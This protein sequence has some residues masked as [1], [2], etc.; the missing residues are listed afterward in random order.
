[1]DNFIQTIKDYMAHV[2]DFN[3]KRIMQ[4]AITLIDSELNI[5]DEEI[6]IL[7]E[8]F[9]SLK[10]DYTLKIIQDPTNL[11]FCITISKQGIPTIKNKHELNILV[12]ELKR[13]SLNASISKIEKSAL[14]FLDAS[15]HI[16]ENEFYII[17][18]IIRYL[19]NDW[20][21]ATIE[22]KK[23]LGEDVRISRLIPTYSKQL[24]KKGFDGKQ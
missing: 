9:M 3:S 2:T 23:Y 24:V 8:I 5:T 4:E 7:N 13:V 16:E 22:T 11:D 20:M 17:Q 18:N 21:L 10:E 14:I 1:M 12:N 6:N 15:E 19:N